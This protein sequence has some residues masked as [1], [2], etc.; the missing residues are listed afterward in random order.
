MVNYL[1]LHIPYLACR[2]PQWADKEV[3]FGS[4]QFSEAISDIK[5]SVL[6]AV[7]LHPFR[8]SESFELETDFSKEGTV[9]ET[10][11]QHFHGN[12]QG[13]GS[14]T[15]HIRGNYQRSFLD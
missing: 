7:G 2:T 14:D 4:K 12:V 8:L 11:W 3:P 10:W 5:D 1:R 15:P 9:A 6:S 13:P